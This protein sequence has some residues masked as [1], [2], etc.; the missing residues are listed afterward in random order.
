MVLEREGTIAAGG[1]AKTKIEKYE[2]EREAVFGMEVGECDE[3]GR[4]A[5]GGEEEEEEMGREEIL[6][7]R[8]ERQ[9]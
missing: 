9:D 1:E 4:T 8:R 2:W 7:E 5:G 6:K 3:R